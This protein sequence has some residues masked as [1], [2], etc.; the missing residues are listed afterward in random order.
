MHTIANPASKKRKVEKMSR[1]EKAMEKALDAFTK[2]QCEAEERVQRYEEERWK[3]KTEIKEIEEKA[4]RPRT[5]DEDAAD[6]G[7]D[8]SK[9]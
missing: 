7:T 8:V 3:K 6:D 5:R 1:A 4:R 9:K 2:H